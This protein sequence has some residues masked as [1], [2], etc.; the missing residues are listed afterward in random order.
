[1][2][3]ST[4][5]RFW[6]STPDIDSCQILSS[7]LDR[8]GRWIEVADAK[9]GAVL[10]FVT[11]VAGVLVEPT[12]AAGCALAVALRED[13][14]TVQVVRSTIWTVLVLLPGVSAFRS[15]GLAFRTLTP[16]LIRDQE[17]GHLFFGDV[18]TFDLAEWQRWAEDINAGDFQ[19]ELAEQVHTTARI[20][21]AKHQYVNQAI[22]YVVRFTIPIG[23]LL[24]AVST[25]AG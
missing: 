22:R 25:G 2:G 4:V 19:R 15:I 16:T 8:N 6:R 23:I 14:S 10:V 5:K 21:V 12:T 1:M 9:A 24:Y 3:P 11:A 17:T 7:L 13:P 18:A 20:A